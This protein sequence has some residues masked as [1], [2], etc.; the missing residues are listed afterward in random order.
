MLFNLTVCPKQAHKCKNIRKQLQKYKITKIHK[1]TNTQ[2]HKRYASKLLALNKHTR[3]NTQVHKYTS[4]QVHRNKNVQLHKYNFM[5]NQR[6][7][8]TTCILV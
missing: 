5:H 4:T 8:R 2:P 3:E 1:H 6:Q 7:I